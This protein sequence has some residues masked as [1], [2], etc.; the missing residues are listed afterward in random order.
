MDQRLCVSMLVGWEFL[1]YQLSEV[2]QAYVE[3][4]ND[5][6]RFED[7]RRDT[8]RFEQKRHGQRSN[9]DVGVDVILEHERYRKAPVKYRHGDGDNFEVVLEYPIKFWA[10]SITGEL[11]FGLTIAFEKSERWVLALRHGEAAVRKYDCRNDQEWCAKVKEYLEQ[12]FAQEVFTF[13][14]EDD[15]TQPEAA[16]QLLGLIKYFN[17][18]ASGEHETFHALATES[19][20]AMFFNCKAGSARDALEQ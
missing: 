2:M 13:E 20:L 14:A 10:E 9:E 12:K 1:S 17:R 6:L 15:W 3:F 19:S 8:L 5:P 16:R 7:Q 11:D 18:F 4:Y